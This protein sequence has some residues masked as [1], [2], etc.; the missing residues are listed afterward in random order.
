MR[1]FRSG[2]NW[3][4]RNWV[5]NDAIHFL[6]TQIEDAWPEKH[7][8]DGTVASSQHDANNPNSDHRP[9]P[10][11]GSGVV[12]ALDM[13]E[14]TEDDGAILCEELR[15]S[16]DSR[17]KYVIHEGRIFASYSTATRPAWT[18]GPYTGYNA[19]TNHAHVSVNRTAG[20]GNWDIR[21]GEDMVTRADKADDGLDVLRSS[22]QRGLSAGVVTE[23]T[24]PGGVAFNDEIVA[25]LERAFGFDVKKRLADLEREAS[26][27]AQEIAVL[28]A[29]IGV[30]EGQAGG[31]PHTH[32][33]YVQRGQSYRIG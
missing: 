20:P 33:E 2:K 30:L 5:V 25:M 7:A 4:G 6:A 3:E 26:L 1:F 27:Q 29:R 18:W 32:P 14:V 9:Y 10:Y 15:R 11:N 19:H 22:F 31:G 21:L 12:Y 13:G 24:Q 17:L 28:R 8:S 16:R 23:H